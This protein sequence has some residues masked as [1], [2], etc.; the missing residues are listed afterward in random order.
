M[1]QVRGENLVLYVTLAVA[2]PVFFVVSVSSAMA[3]AGIVLM[4]YLG[5]RSHQA[6]LGQTA[7]RVSSESAPDLYRLMEKACQRLA[8]PSP[9]FYV[10]KSPDLNAY[11]T[12]FGGAGTVV[13]YSGIVELLTPDELTFIIG[14]ELTH[15]KC[16]HCRY[17]VFTNATIGTAWNQTVAHLA[18]LIFKFWSRKAEFTCDR[19]GLVACKN[20]AVAMMALAKLEF[21][22]TEQAVQFARAAISGNPAVDNWLATHPDTRN[23]I[24]AV[25][26]YSRTPEF[27]RLE[28][29]TS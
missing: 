17:S 27:R 3:F 9:E 11:A 22:K 14:H 13:L 23:R 1:L 24:A 10:E 4:S 12:G 2:V 8:M 7:F 18:D 25:S 15:I 16:R 21:P 5:I 20:P 28:S 29:L 19:G 6:R 26:S